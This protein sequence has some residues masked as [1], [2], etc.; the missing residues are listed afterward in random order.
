MK[1]SVRQIIQVYRTWFM[2]V[3]VE[4]WWNGADH[5]RNLLGG[6]RGGAMPPICFGPTEVFFATKL[7]KGN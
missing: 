6:G 1:L 7:K 2:N 3:A 5:R 4:H